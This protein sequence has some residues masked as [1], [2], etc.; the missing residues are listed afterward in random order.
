MK[1]FS[2]YNTL[3]IFQSFDKVDSNSFC[4]SSDVSVKRLVC[5]ELPALPFG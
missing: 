2:Y 4:S 5:L 3:T 1:I